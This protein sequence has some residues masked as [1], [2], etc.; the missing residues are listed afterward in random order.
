[1][2]RYIAGVPAAR[3]NKGHPR[4]EA[5]RQRAAERAAVHVCGP[6]CKRFRKASSTKGEA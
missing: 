6:T 3:M 4:R 5:R 2:P 1:M